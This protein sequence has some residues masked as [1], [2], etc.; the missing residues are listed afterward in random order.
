MT[1]ER[2]ATGA[3]IAL[4]MVTIPVLIA[5]F[6]WAVAPYFDKGRSDYDR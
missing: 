3:V 1:V 5:F 4:L 2:V 6:R